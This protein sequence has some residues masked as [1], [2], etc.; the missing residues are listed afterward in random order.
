MTNKF[1]DKYNDR[2]VFVNGI[3]EFE[4]IDEDE[5]KLFF[6]KDLLRTHTTCV[7]CTEEG[8]HRMYVIPLITFLNTYVPYSANVDDLLISMN[9]QLNKNDEAQKNLEP[10][11]NEEQDDKASNVQC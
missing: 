9:N 4:D 6:G 8:T 5:V 2:V 3:C 1:I 11:A 10:Q 7:Y